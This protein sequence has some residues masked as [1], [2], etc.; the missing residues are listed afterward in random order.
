LRR[1]YHKDNK[2]SKNKDN[3]KNKRQEG[4]AM[5]NYNVNAK[6]V[7][8]PDFPGFYH[9]SYF[10]GYYPQAMR[11]ART[12]SNEPPV[13]PNT[14]RI[15]DPSVRVNEPSLAGRKMRL[16]GQHIETTYDLFGNG[17]VI[18]R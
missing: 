6:A 2:K 9:Q 13:F 1:W 15:D 4:A 11:L 12:T 14:T 18:A 7:F 3:K 8:S 17:F 5:T 16:L 10:D